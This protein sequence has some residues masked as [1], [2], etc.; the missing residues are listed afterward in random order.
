MPKGRQRPNPRQA[1]YRSPKP[2]TRIV[3][4]TK[5]GRE[6]VPENPLDNVVVRGQY[7]ERCI[8]IE[9]IHDYIRNLAG[10]RED[11]RCW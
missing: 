3:T 9:V 7:L 11:E 10:I 2:K 1:K 6:E 5:A 4:S 8:E